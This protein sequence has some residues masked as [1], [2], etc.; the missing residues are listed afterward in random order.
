MPIGNVG[1][2]NPS[3][4]KLTSYLGQLGGYMTTNKIGKVAVGANAAWRR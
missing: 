2:F 4:E 3:K 1:V